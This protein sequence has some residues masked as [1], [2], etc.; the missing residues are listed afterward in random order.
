MKR[1]N[2]YYKNAMVNKNKGVLP[3]VSRKSFIGNLKLR[4]ETMR[5]IKEV[6]KEYKK[7]G[8]KIEFKDKIASEICESIRNIKT[9]T[10]E[11]ELQKLEYMINLNKIINNW[12]ELRPILIRYFEEK[13]LKNERG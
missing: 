11:E 3:K 9:E 2:S 7:N 10:K 1:Y 13:K 5:S 6:E 12:E 4:N 8:E